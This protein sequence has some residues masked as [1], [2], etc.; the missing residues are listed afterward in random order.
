MA[1]KLHSVNEKEAR[2]AVYEALK[3]EGV[4]ITKT[5]VDKVMDKANDLAF[6]A[7]VSGKAIKAQGLGT[8]EVRAHSE[9]HYVLP[10]GTTGTA[11]AGFHVEFVESKKLLEA[12]N[13][14]KA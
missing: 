9:R 1:D 12:L 13:S 10:D 7:L 11:P 4:K 5:L 8:L 14:V 3:A 2:D 6:N